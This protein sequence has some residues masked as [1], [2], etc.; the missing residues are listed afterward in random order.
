MKVFVCNE[1]KLDIIDLPLKIEGV[2]WVNDLDNHNEPIVSIEAV[3]GNWVIKGNINYAIV[4]DTMELSNAILEPNHLYY[5]KGDTIKKPIYVTSDFDDTFSLY[6]IKDGVNQFTIGRTNSTITFQSPYLSE[7]SITIVFMNGV[8]KAI[9]AKTEEVYFHHL[10][11]FDQEIYFNNSDEIFLYGLRIILLKKYIFINNPLGQV[12]VDTATFFPLKFSFYDVPYTPIKELP[13]FKEDDYYVR[14]PRIRRFIENYEIDIA[15]PPQKEQEEDM[16]VILLLG[17]MLTMGATS[18]TTLATVFLRIANGEATWAN[19]WASI[20]V[21]VVMLMGTILWPTLTRK[22]KKKQRIKKNFKRIEKYT[23]YIEGKKKE[24]NEQLQLQ[25]AILHENLLSLDECYNIILK[26]E[27][28]LW[29]RKAI[30][31]DFLTVRIGIGDVDA[32]IDIHYSEEDFVMEEDDMKNLASTVVNHSKVL[33]E[34]PISYS[35]NNVNVTAVVGQGNLLNTMINNIM[36]QLITYYGYDELKI[37]TFTNTENVDSWEYLKF[38]PHAFNDEKTLRFFATN[39][40]EATILNDYLMQEFIKRAN[41]EQAALEKE[42]KEKDSTDDDDQDNQQIYAPYYLIFTDDF[43]S[44]RK[45][46]LIEAMLK[47]DLHLGFS[48]VVRENRLRRLPSECQN[49]INVTGEKSTVMSLEPS[50]NFQKTYRTEVSGKYAMSLCAQILSNIPVETESSSHYLPDSI[51]FLD[52]YRV[53]K[54][55]QLNIFNRWRM[56]DSTKTLRA[57]VGVNDTNGPVYLDLHEKKHGPHGLIA[58]TT[59]SGKSEFIITYILSLALNFSP[60]DVAFILI[61]YKGGGLAGAFDNP[62]NGVELPHL[63][64]SITNLDKNELNRSLVSIDSELKRRQEKFN[65]A[66]EE[67]GESTIDIYKYQKFYHEGK[68]KEAIPHLFIIS[69]EFAELKA[70]QPEFMDNLISAARIGRSLGVHLILA[71]QKPSGVVND[72]IWSNTRF[73]VC[74]KV[75]SASDSNEMLKNPD[76]ASIKQAGRFYLQVGYDEV[77]VLG[78]SGYAGAN[79]IP[80]ETTNEEVDRSVNFV[81]NVLEIY[82]TVNEEKNETNVSAEGDQITNILQYITNLAKQENI[83]AKKL[84]YP[85]IPGVV[86]LNALIKKY[87]FKKDANEVVCIL[88]EY[89]DPSMQRQDLLTLHL[90]ELGNTVIYGL[91]GVGREMMLKT[92]MFSTSLFYTTSDIN[93]YLLDFGSESMRVFGSLPQ[94]ADMAFSSD[95]E[96]VDKLIEFILKQIELR[97][98]LFADYN[99]EYKNYCKSNEK[100]P[101]LCFIIN[102]LESFK[103]TYTTYDDTLI[104][105]A[106]EGPRYGVISI[107]TTTS[108]SGLLSK[109]LRNFGNIFVMDMNTK[110]DYVSILG[111]IGNVY[112]ASYD[113][114]GLFKKEIAYEFQTALVYDND[115]LVNYVKAASKKLSDTLT[116]KPIKVPVLPKKVLIDDLLPYVNFLEDVPIGMDRNTI[117]IA[118]YNFRNYKGNLICCNEIGDLK[119]FAQNLC[120]LLRNVANNGVIVFDGEGKLDKDSIK[121][122]GFS[123]SDFENYLKQVENYLDASIVNSSFHISIL[124]YSFDKI[125][126][127]MNKASFDAFVKKYATCSNVNYIF[128]DGAFALKKYVFDAWYMQT[129]MSNSGIWIGPNLMDQGV[130]KMVDLDRKYREKITCDYAWIVKNGSANLIKVVGAGEENEE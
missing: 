11:Y 15:S 51:S 90:N 73:R 33:K 22:W 94:V 66:R 126:S 23:A 70:Q 7:N 129:V 58:G 45:L 74:L 89:D 95:E 28:F 39:E 18:V 63:V 53:G 102:N 10:R 31:R 14:A 41:A 68:L 86:Y 118:R 91:S 36:L 123:T 47:N 124:F 78:Q 109:Y 52:M 83:H 30:Q 55:E 116:Y 121:P 107:I 17:P 40:D 85:N 2:F 122:N 76:A 9:K 81:S 62:S 84:W 120:V 110:D 49:F 54:V 56:N 77:Y 115:N 64:G 119:S 46:P 57:M 50:K 82:K 114:R 127:S 69:D 5:I 96:K 113:G 19:S 87:A 93:Y 20:V 106:R 92:I 60:D 117:E 35:F 13:L 34:V 80:K 88:G 104:K 101:I 27:H 21:A 79:Y 125:L 98:E 25:T 37:V 24:L 6:Q 130:I 105:I 44:I 26:K 111:K 16:P 12:R 8:F 103:E 1:K 29:E 42:D 3:D 108:Q 4:S 38:I 43:P 61:D 97:K 72:Q 71:T 99:G 65:K 100:I 75:Q 48:L 112:P 67:L 128:M 32:K 59:G